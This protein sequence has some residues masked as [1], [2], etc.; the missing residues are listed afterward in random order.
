MNFPVVNESVTAE[1]KKVE[2]SLHHLY[3]G[4]THQQ[5]LILYEKQ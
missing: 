1:V 2:L 5:L 3:D 4:T